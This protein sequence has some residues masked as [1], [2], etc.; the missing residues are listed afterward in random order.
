[1]SF[2]FDHWEI[3]TNSIKKVS[4]RHHVKYAT[5]CNVIL[6]PSRLEYIEA[7]IDLW[8]KASDFSDNIRQVLDEVNTVVSNNP[9]VT[10]ENALKFLYQPTIFNASAILNSPQTKTLSNTLEGN[11]KNGE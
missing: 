8:Y 6:I 10:E 11:D 4:K 1:M 9:S 2:H 7:G 3:N 5:K